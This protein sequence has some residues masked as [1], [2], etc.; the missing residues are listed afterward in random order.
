MRK[1][2]VKNALRYPRLNEQIING[3][4]DLTVYKVF[5]GGSYL[6]RFICPSCNNPILSSRD[7]REFICDCG[8]I[9]KFKKHNKIVVE[10]SGNR[11][12]KCP[13]DIKRKLIKELGDSCY[14][15]GRKIGS[16]LYR[17]GRIYY[18]KRHFDHIIPY[19]RERVSREENWTLSCSRCN[20]YK[21]NMIFKT[22]EECRKYL[23]SRWAKDLERGRIY[24]E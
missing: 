14:W 11:R 1:N 12:R 4:R 6:Y 16:I 21:F 19:S 9:Q 3:Y 8:F 18:L 5:Y 24:E 22:E 20:Q 2:G 10:V 13:V 7:D 17:E 15:C 23:F